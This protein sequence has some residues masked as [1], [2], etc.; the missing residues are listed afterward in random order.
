MEGL[1][2][3]QVPSMDNVHLALEAQY[4]RIPRRA[5]YHEPL[6]QEAQ[7]TQVMLPLAQKA[8]RWHNCMETLA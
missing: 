8:Q 3:F 5:L 6:A 1:T 7:S 2:P 4:A